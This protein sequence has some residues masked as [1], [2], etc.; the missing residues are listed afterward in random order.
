MGCAKRAV[1]TM[2]AI[3]KPMERIDSVVKRSASVN[4]TTGT[5]RSAG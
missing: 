1:G 4:G 5:F 3:R 2:L